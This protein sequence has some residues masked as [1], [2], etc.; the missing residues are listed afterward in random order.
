[1]LDFILDFLFDL[2]LFLP[3]LLKRKW[4]TKQQWS[5]TVEKKKARK[6]PTISRY[7]YYV[8]FQTDEGKRKKL[9]MGKADFDL[10]HKARRYTKKAGHYLP[11]PHSAI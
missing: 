8:V 9:T 4:E 11:D 5:G 2:L 6:I 10:Y 7:R 3:F 1:M